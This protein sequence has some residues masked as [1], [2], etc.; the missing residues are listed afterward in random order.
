MC[1]SC[2]RKKEAAEPR[3]ITIVKNACFFFPLF[4]SSTQFT[5]R[6]ALPSLH[7]LVRSGGALKISI[8]LVRR[9]RALRPFT[10]PPRLDRWC[11]AER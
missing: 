11:A 6:F 1:F 9:K 3:S 8:L 5:Q 4:F 2:N 7:S 10:L